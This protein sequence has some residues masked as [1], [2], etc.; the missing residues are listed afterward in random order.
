MWWVLGCWLGCVMDMEELA[1]P[2]GAVAL[3]ET[4]P[5]RPPPA[6]G[7]T[8]EKLYQLLY[9][10][11]Q[12]ERAHAAGQRARMLAWME[13]MVFET[14][15]IEGMIALARRFRAEDAEAAA[16]LARRDAREAE[17]VTPIYE[18]LVRL[19]ATGQPVTDEALAPLATR[20]EAARAAVDGGTSPQAAAYARAS[21][22]LGRVQPWIDTLSRA[23][24]A[25]LAQCRFF[26]ARRLGPFTNPG[27]YGTWLGT[28]WSGGDFGALRAT[29]RPADEGHMDVGGL[30]STEDLRG[31][32]GQT[33]QGL[34]L[35]VL[36]LFA[37]EEPGLVEAAQV[38]LGQRD[39]L[40]FTPDGG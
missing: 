26:L 33:L 30:W 24:Q 25:T 19:Y 28:T 14:G 17:L 9:A 20:L 16:D 11:E 3:P 36:V 1:K 6:P 35:A 18:E 39:P 29:L 31:R 32:P 7:P 2:H 40:D 10:G 27:D 38:R 5:P 34:Q 15:Q 13:A 21:R 37:L 8:G 4:P 22:R 23:Q 12:G